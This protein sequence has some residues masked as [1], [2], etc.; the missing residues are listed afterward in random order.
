MKLGKKTKIERE[1]TV[2]E[3]NRRN[4]M[5]R[6]MVSSFV[7]FILFIGLVVIQKKIILEGQEQISV[8]QVVTDVER[9]TF[10]TDDNIDK[11]F[12]KRAVLDSLI[13]EGYI[14]KSED[15][16]GHFVSRDMQQKEIVTTK[17]I[18]N[19]AEDYIDKIENP[20]E[21][22]FKIDSLSAN[23]AGTIRQGD[24]VNIYGMSSMTVTKSDGSTEDISAI[25]YDYSFENVYIYRAYTNAGVEIDNESDEGQIANLFSII[26]DKKDVDDYNRMIANKS[27]RMAKVVTR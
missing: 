10:I 15:L 16:I 6:I 22:S 11:Y 25:D 5:K 3:R 26:I 24:Y 1:L 19:R 17:C 4:N 27:I 20:I 18:D 13:P 8:Y 2:R 14:T 12:A 21:I 9:D 23:V 7:A